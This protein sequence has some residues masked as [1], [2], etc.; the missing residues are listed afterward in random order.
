MLRSRGSSSPARYSRNPRRWAGVP[1]RSKPLAR[2]QIGSMAGPEI[3]L[4]SFLLRAADL[5]IMS[6][7]QGSVTTAVIVA[8]LLGDAE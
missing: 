1:D 7:G 4:P 2:I 6:W 8:E 5:N 3:T